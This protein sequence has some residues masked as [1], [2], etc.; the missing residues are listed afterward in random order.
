MMKDIPVVA[1]LFVFVYHGVLNYPNKYQ[2][3]QDFVHQ[4]KCWFLVGVEIEVVIFVR[5]WMCMVCVR[6]VIWS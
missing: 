5:I 1:D 6:T 3:V 2:K 4:P